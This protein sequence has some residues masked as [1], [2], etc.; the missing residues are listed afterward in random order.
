MSEHPAEQLAC[1]A[2]IERFAEMT[3]RA[4]SPVA[5]Q[6]LDAARVYYHQG[7]IAGY[8]A[9]PQGIPEGWVVVPETA[10]LDMHAAFDAEVMKRHPSLTSPGEFWAALLSA[11]PSPPPTGAGECAELEARE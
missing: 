4:V 3:P 2:T 1:F 8:D 11:R 10:T 6:R 5:K 9:N 7:F